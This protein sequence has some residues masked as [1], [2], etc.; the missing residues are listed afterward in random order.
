MLQLRTVF[1]LLVATAVMAAGYGFTS[2]P[3]NGAGVKYGCSHCP[4]PP[5]PPRVV[6]HPRYR[7][8]PCVNHHHSDC[9]YG[10][11]P[12]CYLGDKVKWCDDC[13]H[14]SPYYEYHKHG[15]YKPYTHSRTIYFVKYPTS[16]VRYINRRHPLVQGNY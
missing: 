14:F 11:H 4:K 9:Q 5:R 1:L 3:A 10:A 6:Y 15:Y 12:E 13:Q 16:S 2:V 8:E 7:Q